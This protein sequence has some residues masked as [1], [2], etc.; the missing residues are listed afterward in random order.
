MREGP[1]AQKTQTAQP[2]GTRTAQPR[3]GGTDKQRGANKTNRSG[4]AARPEQTKEGR[5]QTR[6]GKPA[7]TRPMLWGHHAKSGE[8]GRTRGHT[9]SGRKRDQASDGAAKPKK[10]ARP[11][12]AHNKTN[13]HSAPR[14]SRRRTA[15]S[16][17]AQ[18]NTTTTEPSAAG[19]A[20][21]GRATA[22]GG[23]SDTTW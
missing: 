5:H 22:M 23:P 7:E 2:H 17:R 21:A 12:A 20:A 1:A 19:R 13:K 14:A 9:K 15:Q 16:A 11:P 10:E 8:G 3:K 4:G 18:N 6:G